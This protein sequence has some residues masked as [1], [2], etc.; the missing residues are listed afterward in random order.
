M[1]CTLERRLQVCQYICLWVLYLTLERYFQIFAFL[2]FLSCVFRKCSEKLWPSP[3]ATFSLSSKRFWAPKKILLNCNIVYYVCF[4]YL[5]MTTPLINF[6]VVVK[7]FVCVE[8]FKPNCQTLV[9][10]RE[11][12]CWSCEQQHFVHLL[13]THALFIKSV[14]LIHQCLR[15]ERSPGN[16]RTDQGAVSQKNLKAKMILL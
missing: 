8:A 4:V 15:A 16:T 6:S 9:F 14:H 2:F 10:D 7:L 3:F 13:V 11:A 5:T 1:Q 12:C